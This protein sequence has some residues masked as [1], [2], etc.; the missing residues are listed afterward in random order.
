M[1][2]KSVKH[3]LKNYLQVQK[4]GVVGWLK[5]FVL[6][7][8]INVFI[9][10]SLTL[11]VQLGSHSR[12]YAVTSTG[13]KLS[14][15]LISQ[16]TSNVVKNRKDIMKSLIKGSMWLIIWFRI[17]YLRETVTFK[18][19]FLCRYTLNFII[20]DLQVIHLVQAN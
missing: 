20:A 15:R 3:F 6:Q 5:E 8:C 1:A 14:D 18:N 10:G 12:G 16:L 17:I 4:K 7:F 9:H 13:Q 19:W 2:Y 11:I